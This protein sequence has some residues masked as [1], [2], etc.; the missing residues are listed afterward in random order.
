MIASLSGILVSKS[1]EEVVVECGGVGYA[2]TVPLTT[3]ATLPEP[4]GAVKLLVHTHV[5]EDAFVLFGFRAPLEK[6]LF[7]RLISVS[8][9]GPKLAVTIMSGSAIEDL[10]RSIGGGDVKRLTMLPGVG[11]KTAERIVLELGEKIH[12]L[13]PVA[14]K[15]SG[16]PRPVP[17]RH[18]VR[19]DVV[20]ALINLGFKPQ[21]AEDAV[22]KAAEAAGE[23]ADFEG[24][25]REALR[26]LAPG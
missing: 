16:A 19:D 6:R 7:Q 4:G 1:P 3:Y 20:S 26:L 10:V 21:L 8:G 17:R 22:A 15:V 11:K 2:V 14:E 5:R 12:E 24:V 9:I 18:P 23:K 13:G 25:L